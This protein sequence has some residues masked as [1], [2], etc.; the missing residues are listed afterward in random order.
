MQNSCV[1]LDTSDEIKK[2]GRL[3]YK[4]FLGTTYYS[5]YVLIRLTYFYSYFNV[6]C[7]SVYT[8]KCLYLYLKA[9]VSLHYLFTEY[10]VRLGDF[11]IALRCTH[12]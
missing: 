11:L 10:L 12:T 5:N 8:H 2:E 4:L 1:E 6:K 7:V 9:H 3:R